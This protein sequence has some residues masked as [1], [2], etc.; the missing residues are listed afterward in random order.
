MGDQIMGSRWHRFRYTPNLPLYGGER[1][2]AGPAHL[3]LSEEAAGE[4]IVLLKNDNLLPLAGGTRVALFGKATF[5]YVKG[6]GGSGDV[7]VPYIRNISD[8]FA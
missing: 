6:G 3:A 4:G 1:V 7:T 8:G 2:T 5:D